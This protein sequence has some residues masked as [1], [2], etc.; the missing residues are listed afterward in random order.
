[1]KNYDLS[2]RGILKGIGTMAGMATTGSFLSIGPAQAAGNYKIQM[3]LGWL[4]SNGILGEV[5]ADKLGYF[6]E[7]GLELEIVPG[8]PNIDGVASVASGANNLRRS[9]FT[10][11]DASTCCRAANQMCCGRLPAAPV[12]LF[13][14]FREPYP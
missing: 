10:L 1:M 5:M 7:E 2:R 12:H 14:S 8:G 4:A 13:F 9:L 6:A 3:Q 11:T